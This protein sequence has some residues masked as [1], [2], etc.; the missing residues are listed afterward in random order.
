MRTVARIVLLVCVL[1]SLGIVE[2]VDEKITARGIIFIIILV[3]VFLLFWKKADLLRSI[4]SED[5][6]IID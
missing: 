1:G 5:T 6:S 3:V 4:K 2:G